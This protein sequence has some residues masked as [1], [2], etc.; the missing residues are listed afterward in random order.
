M[1]FILSNS[2]IL[3]N[4]HNNNKNRTQPNDIL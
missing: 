2:I 3:T 1:Q 4:K